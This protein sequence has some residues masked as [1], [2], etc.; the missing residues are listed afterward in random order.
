MGVFI[1]HDAAWWPRSPTGW[2][3]A[4]RQDCRGGGGEAGPER[5]AA[6]LPISW[7]GRSL[8]RPPA[9]RERSRRADPAGRGLQKTYHT[10]GLF[11]RD[12]RLPPPGLTR[13]G[14]EK[15]WVWSVRAFRQVSGRAL[16]RAYSIPA[17]KFAFAKKSISMPCAGGSSRP[18]S[19][20]RWSSR[21]PYASLNPVAGRADHRRRT[22]GAWNIERRLARRELLALVRLDPSARTA[23][24]RV[25]RR[26]ASAYR[27][28]TSARPT[29]SC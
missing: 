19:G 20:C 3:D 14:E 6:R 12:V 8:L 10:R 1:T 18:A 4:A 7:W 22:H 28:R 23:T 5:S 24:A 13:S 9:Q 2:H 11:T 26:A 17:A 29:R 25:L 27:Y 15:R 21:I 16:H